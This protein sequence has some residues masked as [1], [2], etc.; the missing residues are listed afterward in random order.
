MDEIKG[1][2]CEVKNCKYHDGSDCCTA[3]HIQ[4]GTQ[5]AKTSTTQRARPS[6]A[7]TAVL[8]SKKTKKTKKAGYHLRIS[9]PLFV[10]LQVQQLKNHLAHI[11]PV[12]YLGKAHGLIL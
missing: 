11:L 4:V 8:V 5:N 10:L 7:A 12:T 9:C 3:G 6:S 2:S 1:I